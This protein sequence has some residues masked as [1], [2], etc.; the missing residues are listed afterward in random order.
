MNPEKLKVIAEELTQDA[1]KEQ[2]HYNPDTGLFTWLMDRGGSARK[3]SIAGHT[4]KIGYRYIL[5]KKK[6]HKEHRLAWL[7][8]YGVWPDQIDHVNHVKY[9]NRIDNLRSV[10]TMENNRNASVGVRNTS[11][12]AGVS[13]YKATSKWA[14]QIGGNGKRKHLGYFDEIGRAHV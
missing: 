6:N 1:L 10:S 11:G 13:W 9:D 5:L 3:G 12:I 14:A 2:L 8:V 7:Y 4:S